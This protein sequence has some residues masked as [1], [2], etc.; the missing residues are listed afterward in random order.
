[1]P[2]VRQNLSVPFLGTNPKGLITHGFSHGGNILTAFS[3]TISATAFVTNSWCS[4]AD[5]NF[6]SP[7]AVGP[8]APQQTV[9]G[10]DPLHHHGTADESPPERGAARDATRRNLTVPR[11][12]TRQLLIHLLLHTGNPCPHHA[13]QLLAHTACRMYCDACDAT[14]M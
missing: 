9:S 8:F 12:L 2:T 11:M 13:T 3:A 14:P 1:M 5:R 4:D 7:F 6:A 10:L